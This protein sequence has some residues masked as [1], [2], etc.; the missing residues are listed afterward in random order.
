MQCKPRSMHTPHTSHDCHMHTHAKQNQV[1]PGEPRIPHH[2]HA[3][4]TFQ[5]WVLQGTVLETKAMT[6][7]TCLKGM[8]LL[9]KSCP[10]AVFIRLVSCQ[11]KQAL[12]VLLFNLCQLQFPS[13][14]FC[15]I[16]VKSP[17]HTL[18][19]NYTSR[20]YL[21]FSSF[22]FAP[23]NFRASLPCNVV[24]SCGCRCRS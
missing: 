20:L 9:S 17:L 24:G 6:Y 10:L 7:E 12:F 16:R 14:Y 4:R 18:S 11:N 5:W 23:F 15:V 13:Q 2:T 3:N 21:L 8:Y 1:M 22:F 19:V